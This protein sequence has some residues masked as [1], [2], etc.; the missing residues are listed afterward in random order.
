MK[1]VFSKILNNLSNLYKVFLLIATIF[2]IIM[3]FP[4]G[5][6]FKYDFQKGSF[7]KYNDLFAPFDFAILKSEK[8]IEKSK[9]QIK[10]DQYFYFYEDTSI[11][12]QQRIT[13]GKL[14]QVS[15]IPQNRQK[16]VFN[17]FESLY[18]KG[19]LALPDIR[20]NIAEGSIILIKSDNVGTKCSLNDFFDMESASKYIDSV[21]Q[22]LGANDSKEA[23]KILKHLLV[24]NIY[25][26]A[27]KTNMEL[28]TRLTD[29]SRTAG[30]I[31]TGQLVIAKGEY[32]TPEKYQILLSFEQEY[33]AKYEANYS[34]ENAWIGQFLLIAIAFLALFLFLQLLQHPI[35][36]STR[37][38]TFILFLILLM[39]AI[40]ALIV[41]INPDYLYLSP[42]CL[43]PIIIR[44]FFDSR[45]SLY[46]Y[47]VSIIIIGFLVPNSFE[48]I[49]YQLITGMMAIT[50]VENFGKRSKFFQV[51]AVIFITY[52]L[53]YIAL[54]LVQDTSLK[55]LQ[56]STFLIFSGNALL[57]LMAF[58]LIYIFEKVFGFVSEVSLM[59]LSNTGNKLLREL[60][61]K[62]PGT[63]Q[64]AVQVANIAEDVINEIGGN[65]LLARVGGLY[66]D[67]G[68]IADPM[69]YIEN[70]STGLNP[71]DELSPEESA[72]VI[73]NHVLQGIEIGYKYKLPEQVIDFIRTHHGT[74]KTRFF[75]MKQKSL[76]PND[77]IDE[78]AFAYPGP[79]PYS[80]ETAVVM[81][82]DSVEAASRS[83]KIH[84][85]E[86]IDKLVDS[87]F[88][89]YLK[90]DQFTNSKI[91]LRELDQIKQFLKKKLRSIYHVRIEYPVK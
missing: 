79:R 68:K 69:F 85:E 35:L 49:F 3:L 44:V 83:L 17:T 13:L 43:A 5:N 45:V 37:N 78:N 4:K 74:S 55:N 7:W 16:E 34:F 84:N 11:A 77:P 50:S 32:I 19:I 29:F 1:K 23:A 64:H 53:I 40:T 80:K 86:N 88:E 21:T 15:S 6:T 61:N 87:I 28:Q 22:K 26:D 24:N 39:V 52:S 57:T 9:Q 82:V 48:Y 72:S 90:E 66:H 8:D 12:D 18:R 56:L 41:K 20:E 38:I 75:Y 59:E 63:F 73:K 70:Q 36:Q 2:I 42:V 71:H 60:S 81:L 30:M 31:S 76:F 10:A 67:I 65:A 25:F 89:G 91:T 33:K 54:T 58:P 62:A 47:L 46:I 51:S 14:L 27:N